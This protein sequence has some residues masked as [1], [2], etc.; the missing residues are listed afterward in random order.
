MSRANWRSINELFHAA[1]ECDADARH[2]FLTEQCA[3]NE[4]LIAQVER[5]LRAHDAS[6]GFLDQPAAA[7]ALQVLSI[8]LAIGTRSGPT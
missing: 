8:R 6:P 5:L 4:E 3:G 1:L 2:A 7:S